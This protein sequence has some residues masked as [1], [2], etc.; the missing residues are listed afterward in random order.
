M[1][2]LAIDSRQKTWDII[3]GGYGSDIAFIDTALKHTFNCIAVDPTR[4][5]I[6]GFSDGA[7]YALSVGITNG[8]LFTHI[9]AFSPG[10]MAPAD[11][12]GKPRLFYKKHCQA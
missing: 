5:A 11:Q 4:I 9:I 7:S 6:E 10:F 8:D 2:L 12:R 1:L 3:L